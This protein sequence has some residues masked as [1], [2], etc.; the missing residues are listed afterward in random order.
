MKPELLAPVGNEEML[1][2]AIDAGADSVYLGIK[3]VN[4][5]AAASNFSVEDAN[6]ITEMCHLKD[7]KVYACINSIIFQEELAGIEK[8]IGKLRVDAVICWD[9]AVLEICKNKGM[10]VHLSTQASASNSRAVKA[11]KRLG[12]ERVVLARECTLEQIRQIKKE[13][14]VEIEVFI[15]G[16][17]CVS[18]SGRCFMSEELYGK[19]ANRG[20]CIQPCRRSYIIKDPE[21]GKEL[22]LDNHHVMSP[23]DLCTMPIID[24]LIDAKI[25]CFK[26]EGR[27]RSPEYVKTAVSAY[28]EAIDLHNKKRLDGRKKK[29]LQERL[30]S[31]YNR[32]F[33]TGFYMGVPIDEWC[34]TYGSKSTMVKE[35]IGK[36]VNYYPKAEVA[37]VK[38]ETG[39]LQIGQEILIIGNSTGVHKEKISSMQIEG[40]DVKNVFK[41]T[42]VGI[43]VSGIVRKNDKVYLWKTRDGYQ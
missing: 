16:A 19:S 8:I 11:Y 17:M 14:G 27:N 7:V 38:I 3:G 25:D 34:D 18:V 6:K 30:R 29:E 24:R 4:M 23:K 33:S 22:E 41:G 31:V 40:K 35:H 20:E 37:E 13:S 21:T 15:H 2:A 1:Q 42:H 26:I 5:R 9:L 39:S 28:R 10:P 43:K 12:A 36:V 32:D